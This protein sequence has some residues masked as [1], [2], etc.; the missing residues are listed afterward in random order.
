MLR[1]KNITKSFE[2]KKILDNF[3][4]EI[5]K[6]EKVALRGPSGRGKTTLI[7][8]ALGFVRPDSGEVEVDGEILSADTVRSIRRKIAFVPQNPA[9]LGS[10]KVEEV[11]SRPLE[12]KANRRLNVDRA[13][14]VAAL[15]KLNLGEDALDQNFSELSGGE[16]QRV[17][18]AVAGLLRRPIWLLDEPTSALDKSNVSDAAEYVLS[19]R[20]VAALSITHD[21]RW[22][23]LCDRIVDL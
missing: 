2:G 5:E 3:S 21:D 18:L 14:I 1:L 12:F 6:G 22:L 13:A 19:D 10:G 8:I 23:A 15:E 20:I 9:A 17:S 16:K 7:S 4:I 11:I